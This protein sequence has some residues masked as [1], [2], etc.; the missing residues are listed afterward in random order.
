MLEYTYIVSGLVLSTDI[1]DFPT[2][3]MKF[4]QF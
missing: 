1:G 3:I 2:M 4:K